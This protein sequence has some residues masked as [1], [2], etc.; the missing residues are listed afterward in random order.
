MVFQGRPWTYFIENKTAV[1]FLLW[2]LDVY[3]FLSQTE[4]VV[5]KFIIVVK[6]F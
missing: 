1:T 6:E 2:S 3:N 5:F 4:C